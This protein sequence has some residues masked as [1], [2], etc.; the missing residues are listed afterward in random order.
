MFILTKGGSVYYT[1]R[2]YEDIFQFHMEYIQGIIEDNKEVTLVTSNKILHNMHAQDVYL[3][4]GYTFF[5]FIMMLV[6]YPN[7]KLLNV[8]IQSHLDR[9]ETIDLNYVDGKTYDGG[10]LGILKMFYPQN[11]E[12]YFGTFDT[13]NTQLRWFFDKNEERHEGV[14]IN[15]WETYKEMVGN[16]TLNYGWIEQY[17]YGMDGEIHWDKLINNEIFLMYNIY[18][19]EDGTMISECPSINFHEFL[20]TL[21][22]SV[23]CRP[24]DEVGGYIQSIIGSD[25]EE[26]EDVT[27]DE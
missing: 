2:S 17:G 5:D 9:L 19:Y 3:E 1:E 11:E 8:Y 23:C 25:D 27:E 14:M 13:Q 24:A 7:L 21:L 12:H 26:L 4:E 18:D 10:H 20:T 22:N 15:T 6:N 16:S